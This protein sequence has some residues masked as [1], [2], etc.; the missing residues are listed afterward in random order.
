[1]LAEV[2]RGQC[3]TDV[4]GQCLDRK[5]IRFIATLLERYEQ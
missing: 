1:M 3:M 4:H 2:K 5:H